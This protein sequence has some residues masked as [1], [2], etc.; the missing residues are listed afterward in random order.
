MCP[1]ACSVD[2]HEHSGHLFKL[3]RHLPWIWPWTPYVRF[4]C[5]YSRKSESA[6]GI[7]KFSVKLINWAGK[8]HCNTPKKNQCQ[9]SKPQASKL[10]TCFDKRLS[11]AHMEQEEEEKKTFLA[12]SLYPDSVKTKRPGFFWRQI[13]RI[14]F[15]YFSMTIIWNLRIHLGASKCQYNRMNYHVSI[16]FCLSK[17]NFLSPFCL[18]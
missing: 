10:A 16:L 4:N 17:N 7:S 11:L 14:Y 12:V 3:S 5:L 1:Y 8:T 2:T 13:K 9:G 6:L 18:V 15:K